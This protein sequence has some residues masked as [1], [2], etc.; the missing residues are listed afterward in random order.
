MSDIVQVLLAHKELIGIVTSA[1]GVLKTGYDVIQSRSRASTRDKLL[2][3]IQGLVA[4]RQALG[5]ERLAGTLGTNSTAALLNSELSKAMSALAQATQRVREKQET[6]GGLG[7]CQRIFLLYKPVGARAWVAS[8]ICWL[9]LLAMPFYVVA[10]WYPWDEE[11]EGSLTTFVQ[12]WKNPEVYLGGLFYLGVFLLARLWGLSERNRRLRNL[13]SK[14]AAG[15]GFAPAVVAAWL[16][17]A[18]GLIFIIAAVPA[19]LEDWVRGTWFGLFGAL[20]AACGLTLYTWG[21][22]H[23][24]SVSVKPAKALVQLSP[25]LLL[26]FT[27]IFNIHGVVRKDFSHDLIGYWRNW[28]REPVIPLFLTPLATL[29]VYAGLRCLQRAFRG[30]T[31]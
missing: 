2:I 14:G 27:V 15:G 22:L 6:D 1:A 4:A 26:F 23:D 12:N 7:L 28:A 8:I 24:P 30:Q 16:Y 11:G 9:A 3:R 10:T 19:G 29:P 20:T 17:W 21:K 13:D 31:T 25:P 5:D 18:L